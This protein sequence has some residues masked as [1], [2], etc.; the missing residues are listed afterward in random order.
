VHG[1][2][3]ALSEGNAE[4]ALATI[5]TVSE[6]GIDMQLYLALVLEYLRQV[7]LMRHAPELRKSI[8]EELGE[9]AAAEA[10]ALASAKD[11]KLAHETLKAFLDA[12]ARMR[13][14]PVPS[15]P[16]ELAVL[17]LSR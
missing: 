1:L 14:A 4:T 15:L 5:R 12:S 8:E 13:F 10:L 16:L 11:S 6:Q 3:A 17:E 7:L 2:A 9:D